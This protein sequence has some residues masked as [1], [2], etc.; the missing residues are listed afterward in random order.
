MREHKYKAWDKKY[1]FGS[2]GSVYS[3]DYRHT[4]KRHQLSAYIDQDGY[5]YFFMQHNGKRTKAV[6]HRYVAR[7]FLPPKPSSKHQVNHKDCNRKNNNISNLE[8]VTSQENTVDGF[9][10]GRKLSVE[11][12]EAMRKG[13]IRYNHTRWHKGEE[14]VCKL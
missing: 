7:L 13:T 14:C 1:E 9:R 5:P 4:G 10:R 12:I 11:Q 6:I 3:L 2:D 8:W